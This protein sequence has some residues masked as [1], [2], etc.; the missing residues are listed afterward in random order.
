VDFNVTQAV[1][2]TKGIHAMIPKSIFK[3]GLRDVPVGRLMEFVC[4]PLPPALAAGVGS[5]HL[6][7]GMIGAHGIDGLP[8]KRLEGVEVEATG[9]RRIFQLATNLAKM[10]VLLFF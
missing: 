1:D 6:E 2:G 8:E 10:L 9:E 4:H 7:V 5:E 3:Y